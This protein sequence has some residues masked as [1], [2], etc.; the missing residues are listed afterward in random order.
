MHRLAENQ[1]GVSCISLRFDSPSEVWFDLTLGSDAFEL[2]VGM[3]GVP[4]F[5]QVARGAFQLAR[6]VNGPQTPSSRCTT[7][8]WRGRA[9]FVSRAISEPA[10]IA[11]DWSSPTRADTLGRR[12]FRARRSLAATE[13][14]D[15]T[16]DSR[17]PGPVPA[18]IAVRPA[19][20]HHR[21]PL[22]TRPPRHETGRAPS[23]FHESSDRRKRS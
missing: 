1:F 4:R 18:K 15:F 14:P 23:P 5:S 3:D 13:V 9:I 10:P 6:S 8:R 19:F 17:P 7:T 22:R 11:S 12:P 20:S 21:D 16:P 2:P